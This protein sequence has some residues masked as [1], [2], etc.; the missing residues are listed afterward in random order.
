MS[1]KAIAEET[2]ARL[3]AGETVHET[4]KETE[5]KQVKQADPCFIVGSA[6]F[7][8][9]KQAQ[10]QKTAANAAC[11]T[12]SLS[13]EETCETTLPAQLVDGLERLQAMAVPRITRPEAWLPIV[14]DAV[15][16]AADGW[17]SQ[18]QALG[19]TSLDLFGAVTD[20]EGDPAAAGLAVWLDARRILLLDERTCIVDAGAGARAVFTRRAS[21]GAVLLWDLG[22]AAC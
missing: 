16:L 13:R 18:A 9:L 10:P 4:K 21:A 22:R 7:T 8:P 3:R 1:L 11:F 12:V 14:A 20:P 19:W 17:A 6:G 5:L 2:L 15:R